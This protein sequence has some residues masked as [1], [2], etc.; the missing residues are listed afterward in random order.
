MALTFE[1]ARHEILET[2][3]ACTLCLKNVSTTTPWIMQTE[4]LQMQFNHTE[5]HLFYN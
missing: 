5:F 2:P 4:M 3:L 1:S